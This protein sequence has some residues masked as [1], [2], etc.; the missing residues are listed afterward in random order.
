MRDKKLKVAFP[1]CF[2][3]QAEG[4][5]CNHNFQHYSRA[6]YKTYKTIHNNF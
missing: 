2:I 5:D 1:R 4:E 3:F 6:V